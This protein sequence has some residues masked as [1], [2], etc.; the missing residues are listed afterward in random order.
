MS[1]LFLGI[2]VSGNDFSPEVIPTIRQALQQATITQIKAIATLDKRREHPL[3]AAL[4]KEFAAEIF[5]FS[6][7]ILEQQR[8]RLANPSERLY[9]HIGCHG[10]AEAAALSGA[11]PTAWLVIEKTICHKVTFAVAGTRESVS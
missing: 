5:A 11:G 9:Q 1:L 10:V 8:E 7:T 4:A 3:I 2:G 6:A